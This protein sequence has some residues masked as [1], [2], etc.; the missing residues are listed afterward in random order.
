M[1]IEKLR[2]KL[3]EELDRQIIS[4]TTL[5]SSFR[6]ITEASRKT[7]AY[8]DHRYI[9][10]YYYL[11][12]HI[13]PKTFLE[14]GFRLGL[15]SGCFLKSCK[16]VES[17]L[18][19]Q[20]QGQ[21]FYSPKLGMKNVLDNFAGKVDVYVGDFTDVKF[22]QRLSTEQ[23]QLVVINEEMTYDEHRLYLD[24]LWPHLEMGGLIVMDYLESHE[25]ARTTYFDFCKV[26]NRDPITIKT[27]YGVG[28]IQK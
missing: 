24:I 14:V 28:L 1:D 26:H 7:S 8:T 13:Q 5:L 9:P 10:F 19:F 18:A 27:R 15:L 12:K 3:Q 21:L 22:R 17:F 4:A 23:W 11:G 25:P 20:K 16:S 6:V 2:I